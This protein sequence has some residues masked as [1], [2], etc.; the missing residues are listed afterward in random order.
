M[1][2]SDLDR[3]ADIA[4][5]NPYW[6]PR[7]IDRAALRTTLQDAYDGVRPREARS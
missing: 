7:P 6:N 4:S 5:A 3:A 2:E 1:S